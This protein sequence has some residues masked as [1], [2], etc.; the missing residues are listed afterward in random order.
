MD[1]GE[2]VIANHILPLKSQ[3][4]WKLTKFFY[5]NLSKNICFDVSCESS[6]QAEDSHEISSIIFSEK[7]N[8]KVVMTVVGC[9]RDW[10]IKG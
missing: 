1:D 9:S 7:K 6:A 8:E 3:V 2:T 5:C 10:R 4:K